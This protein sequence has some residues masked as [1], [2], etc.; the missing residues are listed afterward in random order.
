MAL[1]RHTNAGMKYSS[2]NAIGF[3]CQDREFAIWIFRASIVFG[4][5]LFVVVFYIRS[6]QKIR[7]LRRDVQQVKN[8]ISNQEKQ[9][10]VRSTEVERL[11]DGRKIIPMAC[12]MGMHLPTEMQYVRQVQV[13]EGKEEP[14]AYADNDVMSF[15]AW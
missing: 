11:K 12:K 7:D 8:D 2:G 13:I 4:A 9:L 3:G 6:N 15:Y 5:I 1:A 14:R 10:Q